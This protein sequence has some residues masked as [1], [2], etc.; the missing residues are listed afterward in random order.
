MGN[1]MIAFF[2]KYLLENVFQ[3]KENMARELGVSKRSIQRA[4]NQ[5]A[6]AKG[7]SM[8]FEL[9]IGYC[10]EYHISFD[11]IID[12]YN[13]HI[14]LHDDALSEKHA[15]YQNILWNVGSVPSQKEEMYRSSLRFIHL[16]SLKLCPECRCWCNPWGGHMD[17]RKKKCFLSFIAHTLEKELMNERKDDRYE[18]DTN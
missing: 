2:L 14:L 5:K 18:Y 15:A 12:S 16:A 4:I 13:Q 3:S 9:A 10:V 7:T 6:S 8:A 11:S 1:D 17:I